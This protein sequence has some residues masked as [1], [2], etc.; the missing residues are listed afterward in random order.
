MKKYPKKTS[1]TLKVIK[2]TIIGELLFAGTAFYFW[3]RLSRSQDYRYKMKE[4]HP[5]ILHYYYILLETVSGSSQK[6]MDAI[7]WKTSE[8]K[9]S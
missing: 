2:F 9:E 6:D 3:W 1:G 4:N 8:T 5:A 7:Q